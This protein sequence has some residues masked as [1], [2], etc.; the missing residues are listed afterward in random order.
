MADLQTYLI[1]P[2]GICPL[3]IKHNYDLDAYSGILNEGLKGMKG[4]NHLS[5]GGL[6]TP[7]ESTIISGVLL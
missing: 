2:A 7:L 4:L 6:Y 5:D 1:P 3:V